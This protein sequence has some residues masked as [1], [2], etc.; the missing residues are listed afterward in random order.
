MN[1]MKS[2]KLLFIINPKS[3]NNT[4]DWHQQIQ[5]YFKSSNNYH[6]ELFDLP[7]PCDPE[8][9]KQKIHEYQPQRVIAVGGDGTVKLAAQCLKETDT[10]LGILPAGSA[11]GMAKELNIPL[12]I[13]RALDVAVFGNTRKIHLVK[14]NDELCIHLSDIGFNAFVV[15]KF[16]AEHK[17]GMWSYVKAAWKVLWRH[18]H[19]QVKIQTDKNWVKRSAAMIVIA[20]ATKYGTGALINP[21]GNLSDEVFEVIVIKKLSIKEIFKMMVTHQPYD[22]SK[23]EIFQ[24]GSLQI[25]SRRRAHFQVDGEYLGKVNNI[26]ATILAHAL[27]VIVPDGISNKQ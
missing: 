23:T 8:K 11:N 22:K 27:E 15:K 7:N 24:T 16:E 10:P 19:M 6:I 21:K 17:R 3:G 26:K 20:N 4:T 13:S 5:N 14:I 2:L 1:E 9:V 18:P 25:Q 12:N